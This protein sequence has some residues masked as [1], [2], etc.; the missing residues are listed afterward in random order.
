MYINGDHLAEA[1]TEFHACVVLLEDTDFAKCAEVMSVDGQAATLL[2]EHIVTEKDI[3]QIAAYAFLV[4]VIAARKAL[5]HPEENE[6]LAEE[7]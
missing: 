6:E 2:L 5:D 1:I 3:P 4:G 7:S